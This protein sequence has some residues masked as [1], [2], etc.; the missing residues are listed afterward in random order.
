MSSQHEMDGGVDAPQFG[1]YKP[2][3]LPKR[4]PPASSFPPL[5]KVVVSD[6]L[7]GNISDELALQ[8]RVELGVAWER[9]RSI[10]D[11]WNGPPMSDKVP[12]AKDYERLLM[13]SDSNLEEQQ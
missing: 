8:R 2:R 7:D 11:I 5:S 9:M 3:F 6:E 10:E 13:M 12:P 1:W 4:D